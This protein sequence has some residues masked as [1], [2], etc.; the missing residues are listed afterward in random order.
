MRF[1]RPIG[2]I[3][4]IGALARLIGI[5]YGLPLWVVADE[6]SFIFGALKMLELKTLVPALHDDAFRGVFYYTPY[7]AHAYLLPFALI[8]AAK[9]A[10]FSGSAAEF[11]NLLRADLSAFFLTAR[12]LSAAVGTATIFFVYKTAR[13]LFKKERVALFSAAFISFAFL[14][15]VFSHWARHWVFAAFALAAVV[16]FLSHPLWSAK[17]RYLLASLASGVGIGIT[18]QAGL[19]GVLAMLWFFIVDR[20]TLR[21]IKRFWV[22]Q[23]VILFLA[24]SAFAY[25]LWPRGFY[26]AEGANT[27]IA[28]GKSAIGLLASYPYYVKDL[29]AREPALLFFL[30]VGAVSLYR[31]EKRIFFVIFLF[32]AFYIAA[33]YFLFLNLSR[34]LLLLYPLFALA[35]G[36]GADAVFERLPNRLRIALTGAIAVLLLIPPL[37]FDALL[38]RNDTRAQALFWAEA[39]FPANVKV[40]AMSP[41]LRLPAL[42]PAVAE[43]RAVEPSAVRSIDLAEEQLDPAQHLPRRF[44]ALNL[45]SNRF[46]NH[47]F[48]SNFDGYL[49]DEKYAYAIYT[50]ALAE[51]RGALAALESRGQEIRRFGG[52]GEAAFALIDGLGGTLADLF[53]ARSIGPAV[54]VREL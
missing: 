12:F 40:V 23:C 30:I 38:V 27:S 15:I 16:F 24:L 20:F 42:P 3:V 25:A 4:A 53:H 50:P 36:F 5:A 47:S 17:K 28:T 14:H 2:L 7:L 10:A 39:N 45:L 1:V 21:D 9:W 44:H 34:F 26:V 43:L 46:R 22:W 11:A 48:F 18:L 32:A 35:A 29:S 31:R 49:A 8:I 6:P 33:F 54:V 13:N 52:S 41:L 19:I 51:E 37:Y